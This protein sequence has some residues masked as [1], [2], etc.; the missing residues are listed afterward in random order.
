MSSLTEE[1]RGILDGAQ[2][3][4]GSEVSEAEL[5]PVEEVLELLKTHTN[6]TSLLQKKLDSVSSAFG[7]AYQLASRAKKKPDGAGQVFDAFEGAPLVAL[8][9]LRTMLDRAIRHME[10]VCNRRK[11]NVVPMSFGGNWTSL[12]EETELP[13][14]VNLDGKDVDAL[15]TEAIEGME[16]GQE[17]E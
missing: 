10:Y 2:E 11:S 16:S 6:L 13:E 12:G 7:M 5:K 3:S 8:R 15:F 1:V 14:S 17:E 4:A 9:D